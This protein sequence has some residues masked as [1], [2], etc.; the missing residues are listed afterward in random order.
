MHIFTEQEKKYLFMN[1]LCNP[2]D[3]QNMNLNLVKVF[4]KYFKQINKS[5]QNLNHLKKKI[6]VLRFD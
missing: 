3:V 2:A 6:K 4:H 1:I 5:E